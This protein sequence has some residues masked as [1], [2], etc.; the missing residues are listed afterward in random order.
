M[1]LGHLHI[2]FQDLSASVEWMERV[3]GKKPAYQNQ[4][5]AVFSFSQM[6]LIFDRTE[7]DSVI[8]IAF[9]S[10]NCDTDFNQLM[11]SG[12]SA[13]I[14]PEDQPW[15]VRAAYIRGPGKTTIEIEQTLK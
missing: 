15:G 6:S 12:A 8:T 7:E 4:N 1:N 14:N 3:L 5:M 10:K 11:A 2:G 13:L 9:D